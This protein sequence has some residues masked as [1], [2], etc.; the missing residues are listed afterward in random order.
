[1]GAWSFFND[2]VP[3]RAQERRDP[4][5]L[6]MRDGFAGLAER[7]HRSGYD[8]GLGSGFHRIRDPG[9]FGFD[10]AAEQWTT[11]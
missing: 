1:M 7:W 10:D 11:S 8:L 4:R 9:S 2:P 3:D 5:A 6:A